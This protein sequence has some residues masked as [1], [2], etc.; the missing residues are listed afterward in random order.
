MRS[1]WANNG[2]MSW[3]GS[4]RGQGRGRRRRHHGG[5]GL[6]LADFNHGGAFRVIHLEA[7]GEIRRRLMDMGFIRGA[8]GKVLREA[9]LKDPIEVELLGYKISLRRAEAQEIFVE[10]IG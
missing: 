1:F 5:R 4:G 7:T 8:T 9:L 10:G 2:P 3:G 6:T